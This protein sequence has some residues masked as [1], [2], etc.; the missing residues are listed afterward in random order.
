MSPQ[1]AFPASEARS[2]A[3]AA[4]VAAARGGDR[5]AF[6]QL[7]ERYGHQLVFALQG[8]MTDRD[9]ALDVAQ[10]AWVR[11]ARGLGSFHVGQRFRPWLF[12]VGFNVLRD[13]QRQAGSRAEFRAE[14][15]LALESAEAGTAHHALRAVDEQEAIR[16][17]L[18]EVPEP[19]QSALRLV[20]VL[21]LDHGEAA[22][23]LG[24]AEGTVK[25]RLSRGRRAFREAYGR[26]VGETV[27]QEKEGAGETPH[28]MP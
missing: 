24:C 4:L 3:D 10:E 18:D 15:L 19:F 1:T 16:L 23:T 28:R 11:V 8:R 13:Q 27:E 7:V 5:E 21:G 14:G 26:L 2:P 20:D 22:A 12:A 6:G 9:L 17:A 25:S